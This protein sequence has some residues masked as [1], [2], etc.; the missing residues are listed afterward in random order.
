MRIDIIR[1]IEVFQD[2]GI[3]YMANLCTLEVRPISAQI[4]SALTEFSTEKVNNME[5]LLVDCTS[6][7]RDAILEICQEIQEVETHVRPTEADRLKLFLTANYESAWSSGAGGLIANVELNKALAKYADLYFLSDQDQPLSEGCYGIR[8]DLNDSRAALQLKN[9]NFDAFL[10]SHSGNLWFA[11]YIRYVNAPTLIPIHVFG[12]HNGQEINNAFLWYSLMRD[13]DAFY[14]SAQVTIDYYCTMMQ[15]RQ[16]FHLIHNGVNSELF[17]PMDKMEAKREV[18]EM[19]DDFRLL[20]RPVIGF[21]SRFQPE[22]GALIFLQLARMNPDFIFLVVAPHLDFYRQRNLPQ[23]LIYSG[24]QPREKL[25]LYF[26]AFDVHCFPSISAEEVCPLSLIESM[27]CGLPIVSTNFTGIKEIINDGAILVNPVSESRIA[28]FAASVLVED[29]NVAINS[30]ICDEK[31]RQSVSD[32]AIER[33]KTFT[34]DHSAQQVIKLIKKLQKKQEM[35]KIFPK[36]QLPISFTQSFDGLGANLVSYTELHEKILS[37]EHYQLDILEGIA[38]T[39]LR[40][41]SSREVGLIL[42]VLCED[43]ERARE[44]WSGCVGLMNSIS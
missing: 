35:S 13:Y 8:I 7:E 17:Y 21:L 11:N 1:N 12:G 19:L 23:N 43:P 2:D 38:L 16:Y 24:S 5:E 15:D 27:A 10:L 29:F 40:N 30:L 32:N 6:G 18:A 22:K 26:N 34:W 41:H 42:E 39:L 9:Y 25:A 36:K 31:R 44:I 37:L 20:D 33:A 14:I 3:Y 4:A 28:T